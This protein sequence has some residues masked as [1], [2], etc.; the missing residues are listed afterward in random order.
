MVKMATFLVLPRF[1]DLALIRQSYIGFKFLP[2]I[3]FG[4][5]AW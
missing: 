2:G 5:S 4:L 1:K 3:Q